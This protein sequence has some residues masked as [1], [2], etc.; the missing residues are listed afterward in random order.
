MILFKKRYIKKM[1]REVAKSFP[2]LKEDEVEIR[3]SFLFMMKA[4]A[5]YKS[6]NREET[7][8]EP[9]INIGSNFFKLTKEVQEGIMAHEIG[10]HETKKDYTIQRLKRNNNW[11]IMHKNKTS[12]YSRPH[13]EQRLKQRY[14]LSE[15]AADNKAAETKYGKSNLQ[16]YKDSISLYKKLSELDKL[17]CAKQ[18]KDIKILAANLEERLAEKRS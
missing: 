2:E 17:I 1:Y 14:L 4:S 16:S 6:L 18:Y 7:K 8:K 10:H 9:E 5:S 3:Y 13:W 12:P 11:N 15:M